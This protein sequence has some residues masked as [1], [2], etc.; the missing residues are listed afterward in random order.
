MSRALILY[1]S[2]GTYSITSTPNDR[3]LG[4]YSLQLYFYLLLEFLTEICWEEVAEEIFSYFFVLMSDLGFELGNWNWNC[5][6]SNAPS[7]GK[8][9]FF[10]IFRFN[11]WPRIRPPGFTSNKPIHYPLD[12]GY[13]QYYP[14]VNFWQNAIT[15]N[16]LCQYTRQTLTE[17][18][19]R[20][21]KWIFHCTT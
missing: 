11:A 4:N 19:V 3:F 8:K 9:I 6:I 7:L 18:G 14:Y 13:L 5:L 20:R 12:H 15:N 17:I 1:K 21:R 16:E 2:G 10:F